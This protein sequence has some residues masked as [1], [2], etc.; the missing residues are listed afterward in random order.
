MDTYLWIMKDPKSKTSFWAED[1]AF[2][3]KMFI[4]LILHNLPMVS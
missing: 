3:I 4:T 1:K 2:N